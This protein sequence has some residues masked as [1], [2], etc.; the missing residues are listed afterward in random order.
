MPD[1]HPLDTSSLLHTAIQRT[2]DSFP[3][4]VRIIMDCL[5]CKIAASEIPATI[6]HEDTEIMA[7][8]DINPQA[9]TH[10]LI[11]PKRHIATVDDADTKDEQLLGRMVLTA[12]K[13]ASK[14]GLSNNGYRLV[15][16]VNSGGGQM[17]YHIHLHLLG[18]R[19]MVW[20]P[21]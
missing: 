10:L 18:G 21:G 6:V 4:F 20:P 1:Q 17:V 15:F 8:R 19:K 13:L 2:I 7:F 9:P 16:N 12:K 14:E 3:T 11:I 5:F